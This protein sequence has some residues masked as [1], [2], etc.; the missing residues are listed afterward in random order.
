MRL[1][2]LIPILVMVMGMS[3]VTLVAPPPTVA[4]SCAMFDEPMKTARADPS[5]SVF[6]G[7][8]GPPGQAGVP[9]RLTRWF[10]GAIPPSGVA[11]LDPQGFEDPMGGMC[12]THAPIS[13]TEWIFVTGRNQVGRYVVTMCTTHAPLDS[14]LGRD[15]LTDAVDVFGQPAIPAPSASAEPASM[16]NVG[17]VLLIGLALLGAIGLVLALFGLAS[18]R[19][20]E[21]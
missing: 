2:S 21:V 12:G 1:R 8:A 16:S 4:C 15:L 5:V 14:D 6:T 7:T 13:G 11:V 3:I 19:G 9:V 17:S 20:H 18:R 10:Q